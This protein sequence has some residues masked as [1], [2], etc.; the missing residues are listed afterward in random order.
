MAASCHVCMLVM[1]VAVLCACMQMEPKGL[2]PG[3]YVSTLLTFI[4][5][6]CFCLR[7]LENR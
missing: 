3:L 4:T 2:K 1:L 5:G 6:C 7:G